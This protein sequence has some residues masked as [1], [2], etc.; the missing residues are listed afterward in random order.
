L[1]RSYTKTNIEILKTIPNPVTNVYRIEI[2]NPEVIFEGENEQSDFCKVNIIF[3]PTEKV[4]EL[5]SL[6]QYFHQ[7][8]NM[9]FSYERIV[10][11]IYEDIMHVYKP[12]DLKV[13]AEFNSRGGISSILTVN[14]Q[15]IRKSYIL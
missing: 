7:F 2:N 8:R 12:K 15:T 13:K 14:S 3:L 10:N 5:E 11:V 9:K 6:K 1:K 4:I